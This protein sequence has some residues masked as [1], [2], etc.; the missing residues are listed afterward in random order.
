MTAPYA[1]VKEAWT[2]GPDSLENPENQDPIVLSKKQLIEFGG[3]DYEKL[4]FT[5]RYDVTDLNYKAN[6]SIALIFDKSIMVSQTDL[7]GIQGEGFATYRLPF[8][9]KYDNQKRIGKHQLDIV[10][11]IRPY[12]TIWHMIDSIKSFL[13]LRGITESVDTRSIIL[14]E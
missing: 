14:K 12:T 3:A 9:P 6:M 10:L 2:G 7:K 4:N 1:E 11:K 13:E 8:L 5:V